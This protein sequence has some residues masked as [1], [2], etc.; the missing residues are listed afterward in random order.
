[1]PNKGHVL[2]KFC[3]FWWTILFALGLS[4]KIASVIL[5]Q[6]VFPG[7]EDDARA[8]GGALDAAERLKTSRKERRRAQKPVTAALCEGLCQSC[9]PR[10]VVRVMLG[11]GMACSARGLQGLDLRGGIRCK[12]KRMLVRVLD[13]FVVA[14]QLMEL[15]VTLLCCGR[16]QGSHQS[17]HSF[18]P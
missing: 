12:G 17:R 3:S 10:A 15:F 4:V 7:F 14:R 13:G 18:G 9:E 6:S 11:E 8:P 16:V 2:G 5:E 1:M